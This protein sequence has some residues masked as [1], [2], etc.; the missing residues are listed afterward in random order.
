MELKNIAILGPRGS[1]GSGLI[2]ELIKEP[3]QFT[4]ISRH[5]STYV[6][7]TPAHSN[8][9]NK[10]ADF[11]SLESLSEAFAG[12]DAIV[13]CVSG[14]ATQYDPSKLIIDA[15][16][17]AGVRFYFANEFVG[18]IKSEQF[19]RMPES[20]VGAKPRIREYLEEL[21]RQ[22]TIQWTALNGGP[23]FD[24]WL[25]KGPAGFDIPNRHAR[26]YGTGNNPLYWTPL[27]TIVRT[28]AKMLMDPTPFVNHPVYIC[29]FI[30]LTQ[31]K[32]L[33]ALESVLDTKFST[34]AVDVAKINKNARI[35]LERGEF[36]KAMR[37]LSISY[38]FYERDSGND[39]SGLLENEKVGVELVGIE[40]AVR[41]AIERWGED[42]PIVQGM[43]MVEPCE[44]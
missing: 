15:A 6:S 7:I 40:E 36:M 37:G 22:E 8:I 20:N 33:A 19:I 43:Y 11:T 21:G 44:V 2:A 1:V 12:Q 31:N 35:A 5:T 30:G 24:M 10:R 17:A 32:L 41:E 4:A 28:V 27:P 13:N 14:S 38:Q 23:F 25:M 42:T 9:T 18:N 26:I 29:P 39:L 16:V 3:T 34:T